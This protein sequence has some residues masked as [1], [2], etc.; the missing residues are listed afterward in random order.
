MINSRITSVLAVMALLISAMV[1]VYA[2]R[3]PEPTASRSVKTGGALCNG[4]HDDTRAIQDTL[5]AAGAKSKDDHNPSV[6]VV[7]PDNCVSGPLMIGSNQWVEFEE[8]AT[9]HALPGAFPNRVIPFLAISGQHNVVIKGNHATIAMNRDEYTDGEWR[10]GVYIYQSSNVTVENL[11]VIGAGGD[12]FTIKGVQT[13]EN[14][15]L[16]DVVAERCARNGIS[17]ISGR[18]VLVKHA[19]ITGTS[20]NG[21]GA[22]AHGPWAG[23]DIEPNGEAG[24]VLQNID[25]EDVQTSQNSGAGLQFTLHGMAD[26]VSIK[27]SNFNSSGDGRKDNG[28]GL[29]YGGIL[30]A[31][32]GNGNP[33]APVQGKIVIEGANI[34]NPNG[35]GVLWKDWSANEPLTIM[36]NI[37]ISNPGAQGGNMNRCGLYYNVRD[38]SGGSQYSRGT[39]LNLEVD[40]LVVKD[41]RNRL[42]RA[43][44]LE[45]DPE[46]PL[47]ANIR[48][49]QDEGKPSPRVQV[50]I[51]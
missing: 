9:L 38:P 14:V 13:P 29:Y 15:T 17:I 48:N 6:K 25:L 5:A 7:I 51:K 12:G 43:V 3:L 28:A 19:V 23:I 37:V 2:Q 50:K 47:Q 4:S 34:N 32:G 46:H 44:W 39:H 8:G 1:A 16:T 20:P 24:E 31:A 41:D 26:E 35:S 45:G 36:R 18:N 49:V 42:I 33:R 22:G 10:A 11:K 21:R 27:I 30:F 40:G